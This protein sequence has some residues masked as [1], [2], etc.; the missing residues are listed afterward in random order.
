MSWTAQKGGLVIQGHNEVRGCLGNISS[1]VWPSVIKEPI[2]RE[3]D[4]SSNDVGVRLVKREAD[5]LHLD[6][7]P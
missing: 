3:A 2:V 5:T 6:M 7:D 4:P 1:E